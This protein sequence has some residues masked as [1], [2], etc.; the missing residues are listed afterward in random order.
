MEIVI[1][2]S[3]LMCIILAGMGFGMLCTEHLKTNVEVCRE[4]EKM[5]RICAHCLKS[6]DADIYSIIGRLKSEGF[7]HLCFM[8]QLSEQY[9]AECYIRSE[10]KNALK[11]C[12]ALAD[13]EMRLLI[14]IG[15]SL[16]TADTESQL[17]L[18]S[19]QLDEVHE[20]YE[21]RC[22]EY[23]TKGKLYRSLGILAGVTVGI[24]V[25]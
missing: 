3:A 2:V 16:G 21:R 20:M 6:S 24:M 4:T 22:S 11:K 5:L 12:T 13:E 7:E 19:A 8:S 10:W 9:D 14:E 1:E 15:S 23:R 18:L 25:I 17:K